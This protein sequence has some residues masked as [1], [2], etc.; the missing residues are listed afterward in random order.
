MRLH[1][2]EITIRP[3][4]IEDREGIEVCVNAAYAKYVPRI[5]KQPAPMLADY[6]ALIARGVVHVIGGP[7]AV[8]GVVVCFPAGD[9]F[10]LENV[11]VDPAYQGTGLG[12]AL[13]DFVEEQ[14]RAG[15]FPEIRLYTHERMTENIPYYQKLGY[16]EVER[17]VEDGYHRVFFRKLLRPSSAPR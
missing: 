8:R 10:F 13:V 7:A 12:H 3:A 16:V 4:R 1:M 11:A 9:H 14:A 2:A 17:R 15:G 5:G 6:Q